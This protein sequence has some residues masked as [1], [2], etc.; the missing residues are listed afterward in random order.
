MCY[1]GQNRY[2]MQKTGD[3]IQL[4]KKNKNLSIIKRS[5]RKKNYETKGTY[6]KTTPRGADGPAAIRC[7]AY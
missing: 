7:A 1:C 6:T 5:L 4:M 2:K 3:N